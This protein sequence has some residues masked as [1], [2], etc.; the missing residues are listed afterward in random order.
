ME[1]QLARIRRSSEI[2]TWL[3]VGSLFTY[4]L[5]LW[6]FWSKTI[7]MPDAVPEVGR[8]VLCAYIALLAV[9]GL[10]STP[11]WMSTI[12]KASD[13]AELLKKGKRSEVFLQTVIPTPLFGI[14]LC[15]AS[16]D[17]KAAKKGSHFEKSLVTLSAISTTTPALK[18]TVQF[19]RAEVTGVFND[20]FEMSSFLYEERM[21]LVVCQFPF[22][23][24]ITLLNRK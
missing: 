4:P 23:G 3:N 13:A 21:F 20:N 15:E 11:I 18:S 14:A 9:A 2:L 8:L 24:L 5:L 17:G 7:P 6:L 1:E 22:P 12:K 16:W 10:L 19:P